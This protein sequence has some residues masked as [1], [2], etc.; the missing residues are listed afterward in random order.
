GRLR[1]QEMRVRSPLDGHVTVLELPGAEVEEALVDFTAAFDAALW[2]DVHPIV[3][4]AMAHMEFVRIHPFTDG[5]GR[6]A[7]LLLQAL[8]H[9]DGLPAL[10]LEAILTWNR[11]AYIAHVARAAQARNPLCLVQFVLKTIDQGLLAG[12][13]MIRAL[14]PH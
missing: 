14:D 5:N 7:R 2:R 1:T 3:R 11:T 8:Q 9:E 4:A 12:R 10:P 13:Q 6:M